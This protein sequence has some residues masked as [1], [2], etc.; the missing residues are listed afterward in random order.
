V[1]IQVA[2]V[3]ITLEGKELDRRQL[4]RPFTIGRAADCDVVVDDSKLSRHHCRIEPHENGWA[5][6]DLESRNG[7]TVGGTRIERHVLEDGDT[8]AAA[9]V[10]VIYQT[11]PFVPGRPIDPAEARQRSTDH[12]NLPTMTSLNRPLPTA[13]VTRADKDPALLDDTIRTPLPFTRPPARPIVA[14]P[15]KDDA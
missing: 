2:F 4:E 13:G 8:V 10:R 7:T 3:I 6:V 11:G 5:V 15:R 9:A 14:R 1:R 12:A